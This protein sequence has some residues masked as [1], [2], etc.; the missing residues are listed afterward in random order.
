M[1]DFGEQA[2]NAQVPRGQ[3]GY[4]D[5]TS[6]GGAPFNM[7]EQAR[8]RNSIV[9]EPEGE[10]SMPTSVQTPRADPLPEARAVP[11]PGEVDEAVMTP[12]PED[13]AAV[14]LLLAAPKID[15][16]GAKGLNPKITRRS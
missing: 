15:G 5:I 9:A 1:K 4:D 3:T 12:V 6:H 14:V 11:V 7:P 2:V 13:D 16:K 8:P 10:G